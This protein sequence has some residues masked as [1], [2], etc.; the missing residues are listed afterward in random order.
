MRTRAFRPEVPG[1]L[2]GRSLLS[3]VAG[4]SANPVVLRLPKFNKFAEEVRSDFQTFAQGG[5]V[6]VLRE[7]LRDVAVIIPFGRVDGL[8]VEINRIVTT[9]QRELRANVPG[10]VQSAQTDILAA[11]RAE[12]EARVKAGDVVVR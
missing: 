4:L 2:E 1:C 8:G 11:T 9:M 6:S 3:G 5:Y 12:V 7:A 10:A